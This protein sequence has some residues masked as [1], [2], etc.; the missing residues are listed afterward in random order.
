MTFATMDA[1]AM[2]TLRASPLGIASWGRS[3]E[4]LKIPSRFIIDS[5]IAGGFPDELPKLE[6]DSRNV[7]YWLD[8]VNRLH[9]PKRPLKD[10][11]YYNKI[12]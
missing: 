4:I 7:K 2:E 5:L 12:T 1:A 3:V 6:I 9:V 8:Q 10:I 11:L